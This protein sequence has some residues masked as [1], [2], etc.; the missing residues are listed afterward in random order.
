ME[1]RLERIEASM[2]ACSSAVGPLSAIL[3]RIESILAVGR[4]IL[5]GAPS[6]EMSDSPAAYAA[7]TWHSDQ[8]ARLTEY[9]P[10]RPQM[11]A[12]HR[13]APGGCAEPPP[14]LPA[15]VEGFHQGWADRKLDMSRSV[16]PLLGGSLLVGA[17]PTSRYHTRNI[18]T[19]NYDILIFLGIIGIAVLISASNYIKRYN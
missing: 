15:G 16:I 9:R 14:P 11:P 4:G 6:Q 7:T 19:Q 17:A 10:G 18:A 8:R 1:R 12:D 13:C 2:A 5:L 3:R